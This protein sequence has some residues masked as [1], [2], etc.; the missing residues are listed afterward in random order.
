MSRLG[1]VVNAGQVLCLLALGAIPLLAIP[2]LDAPVT[3][4]ISLDREYFALPADAE[5]N[6]NGDIGPFCC[7]GRTAIV[8]A[9]DGHPVAYVYYYDFPG[10][11]LTVGNTSYASELA[12]LVSAAIDPADPTSA[13][14][15][16]RIAF[17]ADEM[18]YGFSRTVRC[19][20]LY[21]TGTIGRVSL[22]RIDGQIRYDMQA[23]PMRVVVSTEPPPGDQGATPPP[24]VRVNAPGTVRVHPA[25]C[26]RR[27]DPGPCKANDERYFYDQSFGRC[28]SFSW[29]GCDG[30]VPFQTLRDCIAA[31]EGR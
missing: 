7:T 14:E 17:R 15:Q 8:R 3:A 12:L 18:R 26:A 25:A 5:P 21:F 24:S 4:Q 20:G 13:H 1:R 16:A 31:C 6:N 27:P 11:G 9:S 2:L 28:R 22:E 19:G 23:V 30:V 29:G 10:G